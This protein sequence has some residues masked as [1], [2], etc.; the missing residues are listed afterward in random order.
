M[1]KKIVLGLAL[2]S[3]LFSAH[4]NNCGFLNVTLTNNSGSTCTLRSYHLISGAII[5][6]DIPQKIEN[7]TK[8]LSFAIQQGYA[9][10]PNL[11]VEY[12]CKNKTVNLHSRQQLCVVYPGLIKGNYNSTGDLHADYTSLIGSWWDST[13]G[14]INWN[15]G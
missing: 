4:A 13:P 11:R 3:A 14:E 7:A 9:D 15:I 8:A 10:G 6:G 2:T 12:D 1:N 5:Y